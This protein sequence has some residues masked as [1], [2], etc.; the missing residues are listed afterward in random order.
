MWAKAGDFLHE[1]AEILIALGSLAIAILSL[2]FSA[3]G[4]YVAN[5]AQ[6]YTEGLENGRRSIVLVV[7][8]ADRGNSLKV[9]PLQSGMRF[10]SGRAYF[11]REIVEGAIPVDP[12]DGF[13]LMGSIMSGIEAHVLDSTPA[14]EGYA[15]VS[16]GGI[17]IVIYS[18][19][20]FE[21]QV[22]EDWSLYN[23]TFLAQLGPPESGGQ[24]TARL[25]GLIVGKRINSMGEDVAKQLPDALW[26]SMKEQNFGLPEII[27]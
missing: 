11:P 16:E 13:R 21:G 14:V 10:L 26:D 5:R 3:Y 1:K 18:Y 6:A 12:E 23:I 24:A 9:E 8:P 20:A 19:Y 22:Y 7:D 2:I 4:V 17:P 15:S 27:Q 25:T